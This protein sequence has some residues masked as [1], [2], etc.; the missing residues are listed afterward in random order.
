MGACLLPGREPTPPNP[1]HAIPTIPTIPAATAH[2]SY[3]AA[4]PRQGR[5][6]VETSCPCCLC[7]FPSSAPPRNAAA[8]PPPRCWLW[9]RPAASMAAANHGWGAAAHSRS[10][11]AHG[12]CACMEGVR[13]QGVAGRGGGGGG[14]R[15]TCSW[16]VNHAPCTMLLA[17]WRLATAGPSPAASRAASS[18]R[19]RGARSTCRLRSASGSAGAASTTLT[20]ALSHCVRGGGWRIKMWGAAHNSP[21]TRFWGDPV[22][23]SLHPST[24]EL[25]PRLP[26]AWAG[27]ARPPPMP[28]WWTAGPEEA[29]LRA[30][31]RGGRV[32]ARGVAVGS[33][34]LSVGS[35]Q[36]QWRHTHQQLPT[37]AP[38]EPAV[39]C[40]AR[41]PMKAAAAQ[42]PPLPQ[43]VSTPLRRLL[44]RACHV[45]SLSGA[46]TAAGRV[47]AA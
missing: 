19:V 8:A 26:P 20:P 15:R 16:S 21:A 7:C 9:R 10:W 28:L 43:P 5:S 2:T 18:R 36:W 1:L 23:D 4:V 24:F 40:P 34:Q 22:G 3:A 41:Q 6:S 33:W 47:W 14:R 42:V 35:W 46:A 11:A 25:P 31:W 13:G 27:H 45:P 17:C 37:A 29:L 32:W 38:L 39:P 12:S 30:Q 44:V